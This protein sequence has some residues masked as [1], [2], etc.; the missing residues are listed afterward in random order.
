MINRFTKIRDDLW[1][2]SLPACGYMRN[3]R[4][5]LET[6]AVTPTPILGPY[7]F[8]LFTFI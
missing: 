6:L 2:R 7:W 8:W 3:F 1:G 4:L 5:Q